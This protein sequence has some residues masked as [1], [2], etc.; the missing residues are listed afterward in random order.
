[1]SQ[2]RFLFHCLCLICGLCWASAGCA[3]QGDE[4]GVVARVNGE[5]IF[6]A[7]LEAKHDLKYLAGTVNY[8]ASLERLRSEYGAAL[9]DLVISRLISQYLATRQ[10]EV[11]DQEV[12]ALE[13]QVRADYPEDAFEQMLVEEYIDLDL[14]REQLRTTL[15]QEKIFLKVLRPQISIDYQEVD[16]YYRENIVDFYLPAR[17][18]FLYVQG[19]DRESVAKVMELSREMDDPEEL[20]KRFDR[21]DVHEYTLHEDNIPTEWRAFLD[22][23]DPGQAS[24]VW[25]QNGRDFQSLVLM[26][27]TPSRIVDLAQAYPLI[28]RILV[29]RK[30]QD[31]FDAWLSEEL[32]NARIEVNA[33]LLPGEVQHQTGDAR[34]KPRTAK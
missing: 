24:E 15:S 27:R 25:A 8:S 1:M 2:A 23:L 30:L 16:A 29:E 4:Q 18:R 20:G 32:K 7:Q 34:T 13:A 22:G 14:W 3:P 21:V 31:A 9:S 11:S 10:I 12:E 6:L 26:E 5:P 17:V 28:E 19:P 33:D